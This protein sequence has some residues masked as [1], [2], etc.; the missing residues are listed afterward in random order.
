M[1]TQ[2]TDPNVVTVTNEY[3]TYI[4]TYNIKKKTSNILK[5]RI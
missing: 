2:S 5:L 4:S 3:T 1:H